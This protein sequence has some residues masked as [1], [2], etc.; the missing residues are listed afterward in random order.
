M[1]QDSD[2]VIEKIQKLLAQAAG[3]TFDAERDTA[4]KM[5]D[6]LMVKH[7]I[8][9]FALELHTPKDKRQNKP[10]VYEF[11]LWTALGQR[12]VGTDQ[13]TWAQ[14]Q[15]AL[16]QLF[17]SSVDFT[18]CKMVTYSWKAKVVGYTD[19]LRYLKELFLSLQMQMLQ[20]LSPQVNPNK[21]LIENLVM[22][23]EA[24]YKW[25][26]SFEKLRAAGFYPADLQW[27][28]SIGVKYTYDYRDYC[29]ATGRERKNTGSPKVYFF[30][31]VDGYVKG[32]RSKMNSIAKERLQNSDNSQALV[33]MKDDLTEF[34]YEMFPE[35]RPHPANCDCDRCH[36]CQRP[37]CQRPNCREA[38]KPIR[39]TRALPSR[40][41]DETAAS[42]GRAA[43]RNVDLGGG[44]MGSPTKGALDG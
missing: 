20:A 25:E 4:L 37:T 19:D 24:G 13:E 16:W 22:L 6:T 39:R 42:N 3:T 32:V 14:L 26:A 2:A 27:K 8:D 44:R 35:K 33:L 7:A 12:P 29:E 28:K 36:F 43:G 40:M 41:Y 38:R 31:F 10:E 9:Q 30:S 17:S 21:S 5:A 11:D 18:R 1:S 15:Q 34:M 23:K